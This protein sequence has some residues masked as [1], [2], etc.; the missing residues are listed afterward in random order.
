M[1]SMYLDDEKKFKTEDEPKIGFG[2]QK[3]LDYKQQ[4]EEDAKTSYSPPN[5]GPRIAGNDK[6][7][8]R[9][10]N[11]NF[12]PNTNYMQLMIDA[13]KRGDYNAARYFENMRNAKIN[14]GFGGI[15]QPTNYYNYQSKYDDKIADLRGQLEN[16]EDFSYDIERDGNYKNLANVYHKN[17]REAQKNALAQAAAANGGRLGSNAMIAASL[18]YA[19]QMSQLEGEIPGLRQAAYNMYLNKKADLRNTMN[20][21]MN[22]EAQYYGRW[23]DDYNRRYGI[24]RDQIAD[25]KYDREFAMQDKQVQANLEATLKNDAVQ[26]SLLIGKITPEAAELLGIPEGSPTYEALGNYYQ[27]QMQLAG[28]MGNVPDSLAKE[29]GFSSGGPTLDKIILDEEIKANNFNYNSNS[30]SSSSAYYP[31]SSV[32]YGIV[33]NSQLTNDI[34]NIINENPDDLIGAVEEYAKENGIDRDEAM[35]ELGRLLGVDY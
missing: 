32:D 3:M 23:N 14:A 4:K 31:S 5:M 17:A 11:Y 26:A 15:Y 20:D 27:R 16:Y 30:N 19:D 33:G 2:A 6:T 25:N 21:Y 8:I 29:H 13:E 10:G 35:D 7:A 24:S 22:A 1:K 28:L 9:Y 12:D 34:S 18:G